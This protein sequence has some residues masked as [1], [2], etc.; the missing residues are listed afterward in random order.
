MD[1]ARIFGVICTSH[2]SLFKYYSLNMSLLNKVALVTGSTSGIGLGIA[3]TLAKNGAH[4]IL[5]GFG[6]A[7]EIS[8]LVN[9][10]NDEF[11]VDISYD[12]ADLMKVNEIENMINNAHKQ[13]P[14]GIDILV[15]N[16]GIQHVAPIEKFSVSKWDAIIALNLSASFHTTRLVVPSM[17]E[18]NFGRIINVAR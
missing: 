13:Y 4:I 16:A 17:K 12:S 18:K 1:V 10:M 8:N 9:T 5:N 15:N 2:P 3:R 7:S 11:N 14:S 6:N